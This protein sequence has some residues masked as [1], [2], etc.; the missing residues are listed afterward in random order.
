MR[1]SGRSW[2][3]DKVC[4][5]LALHSGGEELCPITHGHYDVLPPIRQKQSLIPETD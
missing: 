1:P 4:L 2:V 3:G 5:S